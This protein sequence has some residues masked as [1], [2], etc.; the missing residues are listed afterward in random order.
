VSDGV[1]DDG[2]PV[3]VD[4]D[5]DRIG[6]GP[7][8]RLLAAAAVPD[9]SSSTAE[10]GRSLARGGAVH[11]VRI[12]RGEL[13]A[14]VADGD[15]EYAPTIAAEPVRPRIWTAIVR[16]AR[17]NGPLEAAVKGRKQ[18]VQLEHLMTV[19]WEEPLV[20]PAR[21]VRRACTCPAPGECEHVA[22]LAYVV[23]HAID[24]DPSLLLRFRAC[25]SAQQEDSPPAPPPPAPAPMGDVWQPGGALPAL[26]PARPL[27]VGAVLKRL[28]PSGIRS[29]EHDLATVLQRA[30]A[31]FAPSNRR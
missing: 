23:A 31:A 2:R 29:G 30:Y 10:R 25:E 17:G 3:I 24:R 27:P 4:S 26:G 13:S 22:A 12:A 19:D 11:T 21:A 20:P 8:A 14:L 28:G 5:S 6:R 18:S 16:S 9:E 15:D 7:W 1:L